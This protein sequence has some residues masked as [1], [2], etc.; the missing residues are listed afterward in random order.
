LDCSIPNYQIRKSNPA[1]DVHR[2]TIAAG[3]HPA[4]V[5]LPEEECCFGASPVNPFFWAVFFA[6]TG[7]A[8]A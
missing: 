3:H 2:R 6:N 7:S 8:H 5:T 4:M 1:S